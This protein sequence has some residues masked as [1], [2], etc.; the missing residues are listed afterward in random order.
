MPK[1]FKLVKNI[2]VP[3]LSK[4]QKESFDKINKNLDKLR[5]LRGL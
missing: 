1:K 5:K 4:R 2:N 3:K